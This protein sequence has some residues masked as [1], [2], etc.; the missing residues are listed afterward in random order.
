M[1][2]FNPYFTYL[3]IL[4]IYTEV[5][6]WKV[7]RYIVIMTGCHWNC[8]PL[9]CR[10]TVGMGENADRIG[11]NVNFII[12]SMVVAWLTKVCNINNTGNTIII[13]MEVAMVMTVDECHHRVGCNSIGNVVPIVNILWLHRYMT[14]HEYG[15]P[16]TSVLL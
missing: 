11:I 14:Y 15:L 4:C 12:L 3:W 9:V 7:F 16:I 6:T 1:L 10:L 5:G 13:E 2:L 8:H